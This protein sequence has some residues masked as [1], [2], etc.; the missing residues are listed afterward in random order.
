MEIKYGRSK[1]KYLG[2]GV[3]TNFFVPFPYLR[4][5]DIQVFIFKTSDGSAWADYGGSVFINASTIATYAGG[6]PT[7]V[8]VGYEVWIERNTFLFGPRIDFTDSAT[9]TEADLDLAFRQSY[10]VAEEALDE[11][12]N[13][14][15]FVGGSLQSLLDSATSAA[16]TSTTNAAASS[17]SAAAAA[18][19]AAA[20][21]GSA[22]NAANSATAAATSAA[23][24]GAAVGAFGL[25]KA[26]NLSDLTNV[27]N[28]RTSL[29]L[30][31]M[32]VEDTANWLSKAG[33]LS[34]LASATAARTNL[35]VGTG[36]T[37][38]FS[39]L[40][41][42]SLAGTA[43]AG[44][45]HSYNLFSTS[46][47]YERSYERWTSNVFEVGTEPLGTGTGREYRI[48]VRGAG[49][50]ISFYTGNASRWA[51]NASGHLGPTTHNFYDLGSN[52][53][54]MKDGYFQGNLTVGG[55]ISGAIS[56]GGTAGYN[57]LRNGAMDVA[58]RATSYANTTTA[59]Y[60]CVDGWVTWQA[61]SGVSTVSQISASG[62]FASFA[63]CLKLQRNAGATGV[64][65]IT[66]LQV[67]SSID[68]KKLAGKTV[69][70]SLRAHAGANFSATS[71]QMSVQLRTGT[72]NNESSALFSTLGQTGAAVPISATPIIGTTEALYQFSVAIPSTVTQIAVQVGFTPVGT[73]GAD[74][75]LYITGIKLE[76]GS[77]ATSYGPVAFAM[78]LSR[79]KY[80][81]RRYVCDAAANTFLF[82]GFAISTATGVFP[83]T[84]AIQDMR[85]IPAV[86]FSAVGDLNIDD[87]GTLVACT[88]VSLTAS[89]ALVGGVAAGLTNGD[90]LGLVLIPG[91][92]KYLELSSDL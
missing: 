77:S 2:D 72:G 25:L 6:V 24:A 92:G 56:G 16:A 63:N 71:S 26:N 91:S 84:S 51:I 46:A 45:L 78:E 18:T 58:Q 27:G 13:I 9:V 50:F 14:S 87:A 67:L 79:C 7:P 44:A 35:G 32:A 73:A 66:A 29:G 70:L 33:N 11:A 89:G 57:Y 17:A 62:H 43:V 28:A 21:A 1:A 3:T 69:T 86:G 8:P 65:A 64:G 41:W 15:L 85:T 75:A 20:A 76:E 61:L 53:V 4:Q 82:A 31:L 40:V 90:G 39:G 52:A 81:Y 55:T 88:S 74:D 38:L 80:W 68:S 19:S 5:E 36:D 83:V 49:S 10:Y 59:A 37:P 60:G 47:N 12:G 22:T 54:R 34:G 48:N 42:G 30:G 23:N